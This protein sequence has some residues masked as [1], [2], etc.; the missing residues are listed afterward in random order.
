MNSAKRAQTFKT[1]I[2]VVLLAVCLV[3]AGAYGFFSNYNSGS[4]PQSTAST[5]SNY[6]NAKNRVGTLTQE[7]KSSPND[8]GLQQDLGDA[9]YDLGTTALQNA[10][11]EAKEYYFQAVKNYQAVLKT[12]QDLNVLTDMATAA[13]YSQ[14]YDLAE[15]SFQKALSINPNFAPALN[16]YGVFLYEYKKDTATAIRMWQTALN[17][18]PNGPNSAQLES[19]IKQAQNQ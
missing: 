5:K 8:T 10:P 15:Q 1:V 13:Y 11:N 18:D 14:Q 19:M 2:I 4:T 7:L 17:Q 6:T 3:G 12:K 16:N 9:Y